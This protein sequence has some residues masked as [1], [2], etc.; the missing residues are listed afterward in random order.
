MN[1][2]KRTVAAAQFKAECLHLLN[3]VHDQHVTYT[4]TKRGKPYA[5]LVPIVAE[6]PMNYFGCLKD[7]ASTIGDVVGPLDLEWDAEK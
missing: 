2:S 1:K 7:T 6:E 5:K 4:I 3:T